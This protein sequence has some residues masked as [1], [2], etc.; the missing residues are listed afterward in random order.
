MDML[1][2][3]LD[4]F[5]VNA[6]DYY[7]RLI[8]KEYKCTDIDVK[9]LNEPGNL[10][11]TF[12]Q[13]RCYLH[14][15]RDVERE[16]QELFKDT[17]DPEQT[18]IIFGLGMG[19][20][21]DYIRKKRL[22]YRQILVIEPFSNILLELIKQRDIYELLL[23][24]NLFF[25]MFREPR[26]IVPQ[27]MAAALNSSK[28]K[29]IFHLSYRTIFN[30]V[31]E[32]ITRQFTNEKL[33]LQASIATLDYFLIEWSR[34]QIKSF[35]NKTPKASAFYGKFANVPAIIVSAGPSLEKRLDELREIGNKALII[36]PGTG[37]KVC[38]RRGVGAHM[39]LAIDSADATAD[40]VRN[41]NAK[42]LAG[43]YRLSEEVGKA[44]PG[45]I[46]SFVISND[47]LAQYYYYLN[48]WQTEIIN[49]YSSVSS[50]AV[51]F[52]AKLGCN[53]IILVGQDLCY[54]DN[55]FH[56]DEEKDSLNEA[57]RAAW[58][59]DVDINGNKVF[60]DNTFR[61]IRRDMEV[62]YHHSR[63]VFTMINAS[64]AG[65]GIPGVEN[66]K[67]SEVIE[68]Y[69]APNDLDVEDIIREV[70]Q[71]A[72]HDIPKVGSREFIDLLR[73]DIN[74]VENMNTR[75]SEELNK[76]YSMIQRGMKPNRLE[77]QLSFVYEVN[78]ELSENFFYSCVVFPSIN[79]FLVY[80]K[81]A[82]QHYSKVDEFDPIGAVFYENQ[83]IELSNRY[84]N[85]LRNLVDEEPIKQLGQAISKLPM[86]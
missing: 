6:P 41:S 31:F 54:Y 84:L 35:T 12:P 80:Y 13:G 10:I 79:R 34:N 86:I 49:D 48:G 59:E 45:D 70:C 63:D 20:C 43:S 61:A 75:K 60:T 14:S 56:A 5:K 71:R 37:A 28:V 33:S 46:F 74:K 22:K 19:H 57:I 4:Y 17:G 55:K 69:I 65:L 66:W 53:P 2:R 85:T 25:N 62:L 36:A 50:S 9:A 39:A 73:D 83:V 64:E 8:S 11:I 67:L 68:H 16:M 26:D 78:E 38:G 76:L 3:N 15:T 47:F 42:L 44:F 7:E 58:R 1:K 52:A 40:L 82:A 21:V 32:E 27:I 24:K 23:Q 30:D 51:H 81:A 77:S 72:N 29:I 18:L